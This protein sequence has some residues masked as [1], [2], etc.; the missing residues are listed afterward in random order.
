MLYR[1]ILHDNGRDSYSGLAAHDTM[2][3]ARRVR[4]CID[5]F[6][7]LAMSCVT[8][9]SA[10]AKCVMQEPGL[11]HWRRVLFAVMISSEWRPWYRV[12]RILAQ[13][14]KDRREKRKLSVAKL[15]RLAQVSRTQIYDIERL[16]KAATVAFLAQIGEGLG[17]EPW[18]LLL[19]KPVAEAMERAGVQPDGS[20]VVKVR[21]VPIGL[22]PGR[23]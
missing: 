2:V 7:A 3:I 13:N 19:P 12:K 15:A 21:K 17:C 22:S 9:A 1:A 10:I 8:M 16:D 5:V 18:E 11:R 6:V 20:I 4:N 14:L 23:R